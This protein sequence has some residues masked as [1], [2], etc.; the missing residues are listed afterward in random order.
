MKNLSQNLVFDSPR[1]QKH[2]FPAPLPAAL[3][4][5]FGR[6]LGSLH[7]TRGLGTGLH[8]LILP[9]SWCRGK[10]LGVLHKRTAACTPCAWELCPAGLPPCLS[11]RSP[12]RLFLASFCLHLQGAAPEDFSNLPPEQRR[13]KLQ[14][15]V[16]ELNK[17][18][19]KE[20]DQR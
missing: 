8:A 16:D 4:L 6:R 5:P 12:T 3:L 9:P 15:K 18:I 7:G 17:E 20:V 10:G 19:Q 1:S 11:S 13:K 2:F 14:Q